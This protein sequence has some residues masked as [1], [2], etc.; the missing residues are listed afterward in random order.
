M[1]DIVTERV[2]ALK[3]WSANARTH[4]PKQIR[5]I[6]ASIETFG[7][8]NPVLID[9]ERRILA[10]HGRVSAARHLGLSEV[11]CLRLEDMSEA[12]KRA[13]VI[14]DNR[15]A[16]NAGW[17]H[18][19]LAIELASLAEADLDFDIGVLGFDSSEIDLIIEE[20][21][22]EDRSDPED[23]ALPDLAEHAVTRPGDLWQLGS[24]RII[25]GDVRDY[26]TVDDLMM[27]E[28]ARM[29]F[30]DPPYNV[31]I[32][33]HVCGSGAIRHREFAMASG[34]MDKA[35]FTAF[36]R[37]AFEAFVR[38]SANGSIH[39][40]CMDWRHLDEILAAGQEVYTEL[41]N[42]IVWTKDNGGMGSFYRSRHELIFAFKAG[43]APHVNS[44]GLG[45]S[46]RY[47]TNVWEYRGIS[48]G[49]AGR[50]EQLALH[51]TVKPVAMIAD[52]LR[53]CSERADVVLDGFGGSGST[54]IAAERTGRKARVVE[55][56]PVYVDRT[57]RRWQAMTHDDALLVATGETFGDRTRVT[58]EAA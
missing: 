10:G 3:P 2:D 7:F 14:A 23:D 53:D 6:A 32:H 37:K 43:R 31:P 27:G 52:A 30:A 8:T 25:C 56:D 33:G 18:E 47:R 5:Q 24:H 15:L 48:S 39:F 28:R 35:T 49:G 22:A 41:K 40:I 36:L 13:Y 44:F 55:I 46:G 34:E 58:G 1:A 51:P 16:E 50:L 19:T 12:Q 42:L 11:P 17:D 29:V 4:S 54:L 9:G 21:A 57:I 26:A 38:V 45:E 20:A